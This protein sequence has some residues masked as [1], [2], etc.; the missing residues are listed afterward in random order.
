MQMRRTDS[1]I[2]VLLS[3]PELNKYNIT[4]E[5]MALPPF[6]SKIIEG[7]HFTIFVP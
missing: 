2:K 3:E 1:L 4:V 5:Q 7:S 6:L